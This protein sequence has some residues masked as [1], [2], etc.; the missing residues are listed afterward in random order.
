MHMTLISWCLPAVINLVSHSYIL[1]YV[2]IRLIIYVHV[3]VIEYT[4]CKRYSYLITATIYYLIKECMSLDNITNRWNEM[5]SIPYTVRWWQSEIHQILQ[6]SFNGTPNIR[7]LCCASEA[8]ELG[9]CSSDIL[10]WSLHVWYLCIWWANCLVLCS[11][12][13]FAYYISPL[14][15][16]HY[17]RFRRRLCSCDTGF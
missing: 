1:P 4:G 10:C 8:T 17:S 2:H 15:R 5:C 11:C 14:N 7:C 12:S 6:T 13:V 3:Y 9:Q 16:L